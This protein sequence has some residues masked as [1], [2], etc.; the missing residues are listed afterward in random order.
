MMG[1]YR[2]L[3]RIVYRC[4]YPQRNGRMVWFRRF[5]RLP[6]PPYKGLWIERDEK[7]EDGSDWIEIH[8]ND[9]ANIYWDLRKKRFE[10]CCEKYEL[11]SPEDETDLIEKM[12]RC[13]WKQES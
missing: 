5:I 12:V 1:K 7:R 2:V 10:V 4:N 13:G 9:K 11:R 6:F 3:F 8:I